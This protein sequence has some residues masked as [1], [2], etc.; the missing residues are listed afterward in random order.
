MEFLKTVFTKKD[1]FSIFQIVEGGKISPFNQKFVEFNNLKENEDYI[2]LKAF[3]TSIDEINGKAEVTRDFFE[4]KEIT[5]INEQRNTL[6][7]K[8]KL[9]NKA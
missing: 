2:L 5:E 7:K 9:K 4:S 8:N 3:E 6:H 1:E